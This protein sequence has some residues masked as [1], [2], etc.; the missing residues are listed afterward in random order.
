MSITE[1]Q[2]S[3]LAMGVALRFHLETIEGEETN[4]YKYIH[5]HEKW[6]ANELEVNEQFEDLEL[7]ELHASIARLST[8]IENTFRKTL[9]LETE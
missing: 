9:G 7:D 2:V 5:L 3:E 6:E 8:D 4:W 1:Q